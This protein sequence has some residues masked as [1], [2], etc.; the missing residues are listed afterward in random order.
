M[1]VVYQG[2]RHSAL[3]RVVNHWRTWAPHK[4]T[5]RRRLRDAQTQLTISKR[6]RLWQ[7]F[8]QYTAKRRVSRQRTAIA[9]QHFRL[10]TLHGRVQQWA[11]IL[12]IKDAFEQLASGF[13]EGV[14]Q[15]RAVRMLQWWRE[16]L[17]LQKQKYDREEGNWNHMAAYKALRCLAVWQGLVARRQQLMEL[18]QIGQQISVLAA[19]RAA[20]RAWHEVVML[21][22][23][24]QD[25]MLAIITSVLRRQLLTAWSSWTT[26]VSRRQQQKD[27]LQEVVPFG[28]VSCA[29]ACCCVVACP[30]FP[31][32]H[33]GITA[34]T[35]QPSWVAA[36][37]EHHCN[38]WQFDPC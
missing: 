13:E 1:R 37:P 33:T 2:R 27:D 18:E 23:R 6:S 28:R 3:R 38:C 12:D 36:W 10:A 29:Q 21:R 30:A 8:R 22:K 15:R 20:F 24:H 11:H 31:S 35:A 34:R 14:V 5:K 7:A 4:R 17:Q 26:Y 19:G 9:F 16:W 32:A 25:T